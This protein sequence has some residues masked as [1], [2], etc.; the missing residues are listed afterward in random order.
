MSEPLPPDALPPNPDEPPLIPPGDD[1]GPEAIT[2]RPVP[3]EWMVLPGD[4]AV[5]FPEPPPPS[6]TPF[7]IGLGV[8]SVIYVGLFVI[9][10]E[11]ERFASSGLNVLPFVLLALLAYAGEDSTTARTW[12]VMC[13]LGLIGVIGFLEVAVAGRLADTDPNAVRGTLLGVFVA[14]LLAG[15]C[16]LP[17]VGGAAGRVL[18]LSPNSFVHI[19]ALA[20]V[21]GLTVVFL[22]P[23]LALAEPFILSLLKDPDF[24]EKLGESQSLRDE[25]YALA[26]QLPAAF[27]LVGY[28]LRRTLGQAR[29][30]LA[31]VWPNLRQALFAL[32]AVV[33]LVALMMVVD[34]G[35]NWLWTQLGWPTTNQTALQELMKFAIS[36][37]GALVLGVVAGLGEELAVRGVLQPRLGILLPNLFFTAMHLQYH[38]DALLSVFLLGLILGEIR[39]RTNTTTSALV[40]GGYDFLA[41]LLD[42]WGV[43]F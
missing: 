14:L 7:W 28:P 32:A 35:I 43:G 2:A 13:V 42:Y 12:C 36:P 8:F 25:L 1:P 23:L 29:R 20:T 17:G 5:F 10:G 22:V 18:P 40:H 9:G 4:E 39:R 15:C 19:T 41:I 3:G 24:K 30:R 11:A 21:L 34:N 6:H 37:V 26:W 16:F 27:L 31:L 33:A 38:F